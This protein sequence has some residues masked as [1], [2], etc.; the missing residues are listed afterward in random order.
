MV[1]LFWMLPVVS[2]FARGA[3]AAPAGPV[4]AGP[5]FGE[6]KGQEVH[7]LKALSVCHQ[8]ASAVVICILDIHVLQK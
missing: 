3:G 2:R 1:M 4:R 7:F 6:K 5:I 8:C